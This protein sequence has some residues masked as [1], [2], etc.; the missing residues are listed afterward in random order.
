MKKAILLLY[1]LCIVVNLTGCSSLSLA[2]FALHLTTK[3]Y[4]SIDDYPEQPVPLLYDDLLV[5]PD[6]KLFSEC[7]VNQ[8]RSVVKSALLLDEVYILLD[9]TYSAEQYQQ[10]IQRLIEINAVYR[11]DIFEHP[12]Y[13]MVLL[14]SGFYEY[15]IVDEEN[16]QIAYVYAEVALWSRFEDFPG[17]YLPGDI[18]G[19]DI[20]QYVYDS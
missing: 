18:T 16:R 11:K 7:T 10:E 3:V 12:A 5:F 19:I 8:Y 9:C 2:P 6:K 15:A 1:A 17:E 13:I 14:D 20:D 4:D